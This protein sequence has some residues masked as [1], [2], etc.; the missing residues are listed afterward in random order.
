VDVG[1]LVGRRPVVPGGS[2]LCF[3]RPRTVA[4]LLG[5]LHE[6]E[7]E[8]EDGPVTRHGGQGQGISVYF[9]DPDGSLLEFIA[10]ESST[11]SGG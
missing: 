5:H 6:H 3:V 9:R 1:T 7:I 10:Y 2:D 8:V 11:G 4:E